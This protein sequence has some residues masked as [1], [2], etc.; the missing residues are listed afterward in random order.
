MNSSALNFGFSRY[1]DEVDRLSEDVAG[2]RREIKQLKGNQECDCS[3]PLTRGQ[4]WT[5]I[6][7]VST[8][9]VS[10]F[11][12][13]VFSGVSATMREN[14][15]NNAENLFQQSMYNT[16][17]PVPENFP[18]TGNWVACIQGSYSFLYD[19]NGNPSKDG[20]LL[21]ADNVRGP[22]TSQQMSLIAAGVHIN[23]T[24]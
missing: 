13:V 7:V 17:Q 14:A 11:G 19:P 15:N 6:G 8:I 5:I 4:R 20:M 21:H 24:C 23:S 3:E 18:A 1:K 10:V 16:V 9:A 22:F 12:M 2:L